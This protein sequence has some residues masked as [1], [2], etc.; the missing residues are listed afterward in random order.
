M[1]SREEMPM[2]DRSSLRRI[3]IVSTP[4]KPVG[5][6]TGAALGHWIR[7]HGIEVIEDLDSDKNLCELEA[8]LAISVGGDGTVLT[9]ARRMH[10]RPIPTLG[11]NVGKLGFLAEFAVQ[12]IRH[13]ISG[14]RPL[15][16]TIKPRSA[17]GDD[18]ISPEYI[19][20]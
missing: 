17:Q 16:M 19:P 11:V 1:P 15:P 9:T 13:W 12:D 7:Q 6:Q 14:Q 10:D 5:Q 2:F 3:V 4:H 18:T 20:I 8:D